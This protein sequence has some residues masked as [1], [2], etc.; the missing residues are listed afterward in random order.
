M[1]LFY[2]ILFMGDSFYRY[3]SAHVV[4]ELD[5]WEDLFFAFVAQE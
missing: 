1:Y 3:S 5:G 2:L 4:I